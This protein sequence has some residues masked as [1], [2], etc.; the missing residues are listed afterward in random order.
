MSILKFT[1]LLRSLRG[2]PRYAALLR[3]LNLPLD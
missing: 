1:P 2:D 3:K